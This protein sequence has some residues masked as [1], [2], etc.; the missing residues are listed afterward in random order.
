MGAVALGVRE[1]LKSEERSLREGSGRQVEALQRPGRAAPQAASGWVL[2]QNLGAQERSLFAPV[3]GRTNLGTA[4]GVSAGDRVSVGG[5]ESAA[6]PL[7]ASTERRELDL[8]ALARPS[9]VSEGEPADLSERF[10]TQ[11]AQRVVAQAASGQLTSRIALNPAQLGPLE[12]RLELAGDRIAVDFQ[13]HHAMTRELLGDG[14]GKLREG[15]E[16]AGFEVTRLAAEGRGASNS[17]FGGQQGSGFAQH[18]EGSGQASDGARKDGASEWK[19]AKEEG[20]EG[21]DTFGSGRRP[22]SDQT[23]LDITV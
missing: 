16:Q 22:D 11:L 21:A 3:P 13:A 4:S 5:L 8:V 17:A 23:G 9:A 20:S 6:A 12:I 1:A 7:V 19:A 15:L 10:A 14:L 18:N 2:K